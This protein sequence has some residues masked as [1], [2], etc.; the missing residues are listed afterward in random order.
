MLPKKTKNRVSSQRYQH[1]VICREP[2]RD[3]VD[4]SPQS[5]GDDAENDPDKH[6]ADSVLF[7][8]LKSIKMVVQPAFGK[9]LFMRTNFG[10]TAILHHNNAVS[11]DDG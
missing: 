6:E 10:D 8:K 5:T 11:I 4:K 2:Q 7:R 9:Q 3:D 1:R